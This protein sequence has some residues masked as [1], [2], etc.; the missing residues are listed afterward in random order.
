MRV[1]RI[2]LVRRQHQVSLVLGTTSTLEPKWL[3][4]AKVEFQEHKGKEP[5]EH[6]FDDFD[7]VGTALSLVTARAVPPIVDALVG[8][9]ACQIVV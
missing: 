3:R 6:S 5:C 9:K 2:V 4:N 7:D 8:G 1:I